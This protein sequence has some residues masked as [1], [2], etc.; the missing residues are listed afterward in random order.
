MTRLDKNGIMR[1]GKVERFESDGDKEQLQE[2][3]EIGD[4]KSIS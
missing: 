1:L 4:W 3:G 2:R